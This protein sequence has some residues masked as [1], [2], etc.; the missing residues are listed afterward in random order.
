MRCVGEI[1]RIGVQYAATC[2]E[3]S[4]ALHPRAVTS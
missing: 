3:V 2:D 1:D 4:L